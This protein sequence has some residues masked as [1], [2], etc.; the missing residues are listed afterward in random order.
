[1]PPKRLV[2]RLREAGDRVAEKDKELI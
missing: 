2:E 1:M